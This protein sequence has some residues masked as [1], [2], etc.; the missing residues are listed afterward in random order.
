MIVRLSRAMRR[1]PVKAVSQGGIGRR[2]RDYRAEF[3]KITKWRP[4]AIRIRVRS[5]PPRAL[6]I[7]PAESMGPP[8][9]APAIGASVC[10]PACRSATRLWPARGHRADT[11]PANGQI[12]LFGLLLQR[13]TPIGGCGALQASRVPYTGWSD[14]SW[15]G[16]LSEISPR[17]LVELPTWCG[18]TPYHCVPS[19]HPLHSSPASDRT[20]KLYMDD[21]SPLTPTNRHSVQIHPAHS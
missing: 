3:P 10:L 20:N 17:R 12:L 11:A 18:Q 4:P 15:I 6:P 7:G 16:C 9:T 2:V 5:V 1:R 8:A 13:A 21:N 14:A 19:S